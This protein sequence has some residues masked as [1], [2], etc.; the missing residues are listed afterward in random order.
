MFPWEGSISVS[1][2]LSS[3]D[4]SEVLAHAEILNGEVVALVDAVC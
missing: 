4:L 2:I 3:E 1:V